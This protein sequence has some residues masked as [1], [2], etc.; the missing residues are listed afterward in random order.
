MLLDSSV[1]TMMLSARASQS[2]AGHGL[3]FT[4]HVR[5]IILGLANL[6]GGGTNAQSP[7]CFS[8]DV[9]FLDAGGVDGTGPGSAEP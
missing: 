2:I 3:A 9:R 5:K 4:P 7:R 1:G 6:P 8:G